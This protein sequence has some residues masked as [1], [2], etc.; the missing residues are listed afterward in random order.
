MVR[1]K[2]KHINKDH[3]SIIETI[4]IAWHGIKGT[5]RIFGTVTALLIVV[6]CSLML[7]EQQAHLHAPASVLTLS[8]IVI[9]RI[10]LGII[11]IL[12]ELSLVY[13]GIQLASQQSIQLAMV[14]YVF[15]FTLLK[16]IIGLYILQFII[17]LPLA[18]LFYVSTHFMT[19]FPN[20]VLNNIGHTCRSMI[21]IAS[22]IATLYLSI[23]LYLTKAIIV[24]EKTTPWSTIQRSFQVTKSHVWKLLGLFIINIAILIISTISLGIGLL[25]SIP[26]CFINYGVVYKQL[27]HKS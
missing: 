5:K 10:I 22:L 15:N 9:A 27:A 21:V 7:L 4:K 11:S 6:V 23:R 8:T 17:L 3:F 24:A 26:F 18:I 19:L 20:V 1:T 14:N 2:P 13:L 25:W 12:L 16:N